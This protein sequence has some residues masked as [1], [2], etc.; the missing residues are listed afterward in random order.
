MVGASPKATLKVVSAALA[1]IFASALSSAAVY[2]YV[3][4]QGSTIFSTVPLPGKTP[5]AVIGSDAAPPRRDDTPSTPKPSTPAEG[6]RSSSVPSGSA[7][8]RYKDEEGRIVISSV[9]LPGRTPYEVTPIRPPSSNGRSP[10]P[11]TGSPPPASPPYSGAKSGDSAPSFRVSPE[12][13]R[14]RDRDVRRI[15]EGELADQEQLLAKAA[16]PDDRRRHEANIREL[17]KELSR[18]K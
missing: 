15:L 8:Y 4:E 11:S 7:I 13:Q 3:D 5:T 2:K 18:V 14:R 10:P 9:P 16:T 6:A 12:E 17:N 1:G